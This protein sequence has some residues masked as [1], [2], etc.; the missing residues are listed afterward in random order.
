MGRADLYGGNYYLNSNTGGSG[1]VLKYQGSPVIAA[2]YGTYKVIA[3]EQLS[4]GGYNVAWKNSSTG[5]FSIWNT[6]SNGNFVKTVGAAP[7]MGGTEMS[8]KTLEWA[9]HQD[10]NG[11]SAIGM[12]SIETNGTTTTVLDSGYY[13]MLSPSTGT[14][15]SLKY[16]GSAVIA[17]NYGAYKVIATEQVSGGGYDVVWKNSSTGYYS[18]W[19]TDS[20]GNF[21]TTLAAA[22]EV[23]GS[24][25]S[26]KALEPVLHQD[27]NGDG[28]IGASPVVVD[29]D[30]NGIDLLP[31]SSSSAAF[32]MDGQGRERTAWISGADGLL[33]IDL[34][35]NGSAAPDGIINQTEEIVFTAWAPG[36]TSDMA[37]LAQVFDS[38]HDGALSR[39]DAR[40]DDFRIWQD[41]NADGISQSGEVH[42]LSDFGI[43]SIGLNPTGDPSAL[44]DGSII[45]GLSSY[46]RTDG[47]MGIAGDVIFSTDP[48]SHLSNALSQLVQA[49]ASYSDNRGFLTPLEPLSSQYDQAAQGVLAAWRPAA[50]G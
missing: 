18:V 1:P 3:A 4:D 32:D 8:L 37:A 25:P 10:L 40:W 24:A 36:T 9:F 5:L 16:Q 14:G 2:N 39:A 41:L 50:A 46:T 33:A 27:L 42:K 38:N 11:D 19:S 20:N 31:L 43:S 15:Q 47:T 17:A 21:L 30:G 35:A 45:Q 22:P 28:V 34:G 26:L 44:S 23:L 6:D 48:N 7:E 13:F 12:P 49:M 29:L